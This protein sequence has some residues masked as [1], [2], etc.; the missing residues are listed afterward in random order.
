VHTTTGHSRAEAVGRTLCFVTVALIGGAVL[1][2]AWICIQ[3]F[4]RIGV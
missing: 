2:A 1:Y 4:S 3:N